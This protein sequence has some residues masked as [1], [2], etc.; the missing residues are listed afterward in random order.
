MSSTHEAEGFQAQP[1]V[2]LDGLAYVESPRWHEHRL[3]FAHWG[4]GEVIAV[5]G[6]GRSEVI[7]LG[8]PHRNAAE[9]GH[10]LGWSIDWTRDGP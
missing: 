4:A 6:A 1:Q 8:P 2:L 7:T 3:W 9:P 10:G 5:D